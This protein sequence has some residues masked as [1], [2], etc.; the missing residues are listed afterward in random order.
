MFLKRPVSW[1]GPAIIVQFQ[2]FGG[3][4]MSGRQKST[5]LAVLLAM[6]GP[7]G[8]S[9]ATPALIAE[10]QTALDRG[11]AQHAANLAEGALKEQDITALQRGRLLLYHGLAEELLGGAD[12]ATRDFTAALNAPGLPSGE[13]AQ[14][15]LQ[16]G[17]LHDGQ[18]RLD[19][20][21]A[22]YSAVI[23]LKDDGVATALNNRANVYRRQNKFAQ[24]K[25]DYQA[26]LGAGG[27]AQ[28]AWYGLG[29]I[30]EAEN[31]MFAARGFYAK[32]VTA[33]AGYTLASERLAALGG[34]PE[35]AIGN[36]QAP[37]VL[38]APAPSSGEVQTAPLTPPPAEPKAAASAAPPADAPIVLHPP[39]QKRASPPRQV[40]ASAA[41]SPSTVLRPALDQSGA[42]KGEV[43][44]GA[45]RSEEEARTG[46]NKAALKAPDLLAGLQPRVVAV[47]I[48]EKG[49]FYRLRVSLPQEANRGQF[50]SSLTAQG[51]A[52]FP[53]R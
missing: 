27:K 34:P 5:I 44:L 4:V 8:A 30:A 29:Q 53:V 22:D 32:A 38:K 51:V 26:A 46:W 23:A 20:A 10:V 49:R 52:C 25:A 7:C 14:A 24:A 15:L 18:G 39:V 47:D 43:Q 6:A 37:I 45:W 13:R 28:Y 9:P 16:R 48:P 50:C 12:A 35:G 40:Q 17:F 36:P 1:H 11:D 41:P 2:A 33:D 21:A 3:F 31:D 19:Q 42:A